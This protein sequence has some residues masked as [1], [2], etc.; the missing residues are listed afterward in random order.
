MP[1]LIGNY[2]KQE[3]ISRLKKG[4]SVVLQAIRMYEAQN[5]PIADWDFSLNGQK[6][7]EKYFK[8][9]IQYTKEYTA[10][11]LGKL[12]P[13][14]TLNGNTYTGTTYQNSSTS[15]YHAVLSDGII[16]TV[17]AVSGSIWIGIDTNGVTKPNRIG[18]DTFLFV[19]TGQYGLQPLGGKGSPETWSYGDE[20]S[21]DK[22]TAATRTYSCNAEKLGYWCSALIMNDGWEIAK[23]YPW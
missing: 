21:R 10:A 1:T 17:N 12:A 5:E 8:N 19:F 13:R 11:E 16:L 2:K 18:K 3:T 14:T 15:T 20:Y 22:I 4:Y 6:F 7:F 9:Y 23:D